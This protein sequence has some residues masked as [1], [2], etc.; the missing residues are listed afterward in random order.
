M[1]LSANCSRQGRRA[2][3]LKKFG[4]NQSPRNSLI[5]N[6]K[7][8]P[9][10]IHARNVVNIYWPQSRKGLI[11]EIVSFKFSMQVR[12]SQGPPS[13]HRE[14]W[15]ASILVSGALQSV[16]GSAKAR[17]SELRS[18][19]QAL[20]REKTSSK[21]EALRHTTSTRKHSDACTKLNARR[22]EVS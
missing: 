7:A 3:S 4:T 14:E 11:V 15:S 10:C 18:D 12:M 17:Y 9:T 13:G 8:T 22:S 1:L 19:N 2:F 21:T 16:S 5:S 20:G 6:H